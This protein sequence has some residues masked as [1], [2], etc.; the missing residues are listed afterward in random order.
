MAKI[1]YGVHG[2]GHGHAV[3]ACIVSE[4]YPEHTF[5]FVS[6][7]DGLEVLNKAGLNTYE[8]P[9]P[10][11]PIKNH[12]IL[13]TRL[14]L[15]NLKFKLHVG[16]YEKTLRDIIDDFKPDY[17]VSD[18]EYLVPKI[19]KENSIP[20]LSIDNSHIITTAQHKLPFLAAFNYLANA[21]LINKMYSN[22]EKYIIVS[23]FNLPVKEKMSNRVIIPPIHR[24]NVFHHEAKDAGHVI[25][26]QGYTTFSG[27]IP[28]LH[29]IKRNVK[30]YGFDKEGIS[31]NIEFKT[32]SVNGFLHDLATCSYVIC[33]G[34]H[35]LI[36][37]ALYYGKPILSFP[38]SYAFEQ[39]LNAFYLEV[40]GYGKMCRLSQVSQKV[41][42]EFE[43]E[44]D[45]YREKIGCRNFSGNDKFRYYFDAFLNGSSFEET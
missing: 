43:S 12:R 7:S 33:G 8:I 5:L 20:C 19:C 30:V 21:H 40:N 11:T 29:K 13:F 9:N 28:F 41:I 27:F 14:F 36:S 22:V 39:Y 23:F 45:S 2:T 32:N 31:G 42:D 44:L 10:V 1:I 37:E 24:K 17:G 18:Y 38:I 15:E 3:R 35:T 4:M 16:K 6:H 26:Y 25:A 34:G